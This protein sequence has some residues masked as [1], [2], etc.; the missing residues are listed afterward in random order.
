M[1]YMKLKEQLAQ[2]RSSRL[3]TLINVFLKAVSRIA[4]QPGLKR[5]DIHSKKPSILIFVCY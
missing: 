4:S 1:L 2:A 3:E 5:K